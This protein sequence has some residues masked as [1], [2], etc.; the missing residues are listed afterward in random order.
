MWV[1][2][3]SQR[4]KISSWGR[5]GTILPLIS[6]I[7]R[8]SHFRYYSNI[9]GF[10]KKYKNQPV[11]EPLGPQCHCNARFKPKWKSL[12]VRRFQEAPIK[13]RGDYSGTIEVKEK[14]TV[15]DL[16]TNLWFIHLL[17][18]L[19][20]KLG[21]YVKGQVG[22]SLASHTRLWPQQLSPHKGGAAMWGRRRIPGVLL[23]WCLNAT[24][25]WWITRVWVHSSVSRD[26]YLLSGCRIISLLQDRGVGSSTL[27]KPGSARAGIY[28]KL[29]GKWRK[30]GRQ[31]ELLASF[32]WSRGL[33]VKMNFNLNHRQEEC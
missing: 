3:A 12:K 25:S 21:K 17:K 22:K 19:G 31:N 18:Q 6:K 2:S 30:A 9:C 23:P 14:V 10:K 11:A 8:F 20:E 32:K 16:M 4:H 5:L 29:S 13:V 24:Q 33:P 1:K 7:N 26:Q 15:T 27:S 28:G